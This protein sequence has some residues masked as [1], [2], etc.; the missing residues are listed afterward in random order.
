[1]AL[2]K[3]QMTPQCC[4]DLFV[5]RRE[6]SR[7]AQERQR[8]GPAPQPI[9]R[10]RL[11]EERFDRFRRE[12]R[13]AVERPLRIFEPALPEVEMPEPEERLRPVRLE[14]GCVAKA[15]FRTG[16]IALLEE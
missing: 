14:R 4:P 12:R 5:F 3:Q 2:E 10:L 11:I 16:K 13:R 15:R 7:P 9:E 8:F 6:R 1:M